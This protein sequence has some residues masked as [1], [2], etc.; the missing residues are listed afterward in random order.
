MKQLI[1]TLLFLLST[2]YLNAQTDCSKL[3]AQKINLQDEDFEKIQFELTTNFSKLSGCGLDE[4]DVTFLGQPMLLVTLVLEWVND[5][6]ETVT[7]QKLLNEVLKIKATPE[8][9]E[10][11]ELY[12]DFLLLR[13]KKIDL[14]NW[15][16][17]SKLLLK[18]MKDERLVSAI[19]QL[20][21]ENPDRYET[22]DDMISDFNR[23][24]DSDTITDTKVQDEDLPN[25]FKDAELINYH[26]ILKLSNKSGKPLLIY[27]TAYADVNSRKMEDAFLLDSDV[28]ALID[29][30]YYAITLFVDSKKSVPKE[31]I[32]INPK[33]GEKMRTF[34]AFYIKI[35]EEQ[36]KENRQPFFVIVNE[37]GKILKTHGFTLNKNEF[38]QFLK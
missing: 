29:S 28:Q 18:I 37:E 11:M 21:R 35:Q 7:Y 38:Q 1:Y 2:I 3:L 9:R 27:F 4:E 22:F 14:N 36:F 20:L 10:S 6:P 23:I 34:G 17:D 31:S 13:S 12:N 33:N 8:Y 15:A 32:I 5:D 24:V 30:N 25:F 19:Y 16:T 26:E